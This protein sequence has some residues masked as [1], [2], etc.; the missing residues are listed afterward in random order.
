MK[1]LLWNLRFVK[2]NT[3]SM[4]INLKKVE[5]YH[6]VFKGTLFQ[7][8]FVD[9][10]EAKWHCNFCKPSGITYWSTSKNML[11]LILQSKISWWLRFNFSKATQEKRSYS[12]KQ[13]TGLWPATIFSRDGQNI[14]KKVYILA[15]HPQHLQP[16]LVPAAAPCEFQL[17]LRVKMRAGSSDEPSCWGWDNEVDNPQVHRVLH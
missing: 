4:V 8:C 12:T 10:F 11:V 9:G 13:R 1:I 16:V 14:E 7:S 6:I 2:E 5:N 3:L 15:L 17:E